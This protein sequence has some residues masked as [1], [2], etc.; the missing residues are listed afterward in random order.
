MDRE[1]EN[2]SLTNEP[3]D[4]TPTPEIRPGWHVPQPEMLPKETYWPAVLALGVV[5]LLWGVVTT[6]IITIAGFVLSA[7][8]LAGW[9]GDLLHEHE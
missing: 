9:I 7:L 5:F 2:K 3:Q 8:A 1:T 6:F 4:A